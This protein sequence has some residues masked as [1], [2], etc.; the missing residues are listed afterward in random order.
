MT[1][2][3]SAINF[4]RL[5]RRQAKM[6][7]KNQQ[8]LSHPADSL[9]KPHSA[10]RIEVIKQAEAQHEIVTFILRKKADIMATEVDLQPESHRGE[11]GFRD[12]HLPPFHAN[13]VRA[14][15]SKLEQEAAFASSQVK[16]T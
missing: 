5:R 12:V 16:D 6:S 11:L 14:L 7:I 3:G 13:H 1:T 4:D 9:Y 2:I 15:S 8:A 10:P